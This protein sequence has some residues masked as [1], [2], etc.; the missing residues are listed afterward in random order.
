MKL[1]TLELN[2]W[3]PEFYKR[4]KN[5]QQL[6]DVLRELKDTLGLSDQDINV[7]SEVAEQIKQVIFGVA[8]S[9]DTIVYLRRWAQRNY[10]KNYPQVILRAIL[11]EG[12]GWLL[13]KDRERV[14]E[15][16]KKQGLTP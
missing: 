1:S 7:D 8:S 9:E 10:S 14:E 11:Q 5:G 3:A 2:S 12:K 16:L 15:N 4:Y 6:E 13:K